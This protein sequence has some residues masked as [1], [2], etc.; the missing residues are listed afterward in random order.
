MN[1]SMGEIG[2]LIDA[3]DQATKST[4]SLIRSYLPGRNDWDAS[5]RENYTT[6]TMQLRIFRRLRRKFD[7]IEAQASK[8]E[9][10]NGHKTQSQSKDHRVL[11]QPPARRGARPG[12]DRSR[13]AA[14]AANRAEGKT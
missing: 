4:Q 14:K 6:W 10:V 11:P 9:K 7:R 12:R 8:K 3:L 2:G 13:S 5:D 1:L